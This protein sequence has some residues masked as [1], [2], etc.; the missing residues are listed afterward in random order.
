ME[1]AELREILADWTDFDVAAY[2]LGKFIG[3]LPADR[4]FL[5][6]KGIFW[7]EGYPVAKMLD[8]MLESMVAAEVLLK[9]DDLRYRWNPDGP[10]PDLSLEDIEAIEAGRIGG[11]GPEA[12]G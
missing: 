2:R 11:A 8:E 7:I 6:L 3:V 5:S 10:D 4:S 12:A 9:D 1:S